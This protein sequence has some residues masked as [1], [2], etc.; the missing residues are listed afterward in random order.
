MDEITVVMPAYTINEEVWKLT[1]NALDSIGEGPLI[2]IDNASPMGGGYLRSKATTYVRN[3]TNLG[4]AKA[5]N[6]GIKL[7]QTK[8]VAICSTD[9]RVSPNWRQVALE[10]LQEPTVYS[11]HFRMTNYHVSFKYGNTTAYTGKE[12][13]CAIAFFVFD[14]E[15]ALLF[16]EE[17]FNSYEDWDLMTRV[18]K[19][20]YKTAYT[21]KACFQHNHSFTQ[22]Y[23][24]YPGTQENKELFKKK[25]GGYAEDLF[26]LEFPDQMAVDY[27]KGFD[28]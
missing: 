19:Q 17:F 26:A 18:R 12:R 6:Q 15:K 14:R 10:V 25:H 22:K 9:V 13:W 5:C 1:E 3:D 2:I 20:G 27:Q 4:F 8:Y 24:G 23:L 21:N 11:C 28:L 7:A 16:D